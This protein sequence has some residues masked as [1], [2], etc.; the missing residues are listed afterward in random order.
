MI[1]TPPSEASNYAYDANNRL[2]EEITDRILSE[3]LE[4]ELYDSKLEKV[5]KR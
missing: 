2:S 4:E 5:F 3:I 1:P